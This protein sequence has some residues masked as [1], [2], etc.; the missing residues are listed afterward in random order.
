MSANVYNSTIHS[1]HISIIHFYSVLN[2]KYMYTS[3]YLKATAIIVVDTGNIMCCIVYL[4][5]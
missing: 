3:L 1:F 2:S 4:V 5:L